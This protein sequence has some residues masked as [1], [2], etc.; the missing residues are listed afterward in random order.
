MGEAPPA[1]IYRVVD[2]EN[3]GWHPMGGAG[4][5]ILYAADY[6][7]ER[8]LADRPFDQ[9]VTDRGP[10]RPV[11]PITTEDWAELDRLFTLAGRRT[12][13]TLAAALE[14]VFHR[15][16]EDAGP[17]RP[18]KWLAPGG[19]YDTYQA[20]RRAMLAGREGSWESEALITVML[21]GNELNLPDIKGRR[22]ADVDE[23]R[24]AGPSKRVHREAHAA[25]AAMFHRWVTDPARYTEVAETLAA[26]VSTYADEHGEVIPGHATNADP[27]PHTG[28]AVVAD[29]WLQPGGL[30]QQAF[31]DC[32]RLLY[33]TSDHFNYRLI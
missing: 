32:Y 3:Q 5:L 8:D 33:S 6:G 11:E 21:F 12:V 7:F 13:T 2:Q 25:M 22:H 27:V 1:T 18:G 24:A 26:V 14:T 23:R 10:L 16:R 4:E 15:I 9:L 17:D 29:Q 31:S 20:A 30:A 19:G 28:W